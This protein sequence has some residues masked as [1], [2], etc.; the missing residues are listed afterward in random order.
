M[1]L[2]MMITGN[3]FGA[4]DATAAEGGRAESKEL[5]TGTVGDEERTQ[6][7]PTGRQRAQTGI[8]RL[9]T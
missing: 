2:M 9:K 4:V 6:Q 8:T 1:V 7:G 5:S 3:A